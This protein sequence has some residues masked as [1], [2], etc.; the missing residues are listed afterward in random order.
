MK[1]PKVWTVG[2]ILQWTVDFLRK[3]VGIATPRCGNLIGPRL[4]E[5]TDLSIRPLR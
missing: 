1:M 2:A 4:A 5:R 3:G